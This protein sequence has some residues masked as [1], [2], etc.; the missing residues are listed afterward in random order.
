MITARIFHK[1]E[2]YTIL[3]IST[4]YILHEKHF[5]PNNYIN[6][7]GEQVIGQSGKDAMPS[8]L[9]YPFH[10]AKTINT[11]ILSF[12]KFYSNFVGSEG[13]QSQRPKL[14]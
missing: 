12:Q 10:L 3:Y 5:I 1:C 6:I 13:N 7:K 14:N 11:L 2:V 9:D 4:P 8:I